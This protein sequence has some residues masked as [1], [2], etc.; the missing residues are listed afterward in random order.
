MS[1]LRYA[2][3]DPTGNITVL[4]T[5]PVPREKQ[6]AL[7]RAL[8]AEPKVGGEQ[9][10]F[11][12]KPENPACRCR[13]QMMGGEFC[14][15]ATMS[16]AAYLVRNE[17]ADG[18]ETTVPLEVSGAEGVLDCRIRRVDDTFEGT[19]RMPE[20][21]ACDQVELP[22][23]GRKVLLTSVRLDGITH[24]ILKEKIADD[25]EAE[26]MLRVWAAL[27][28]DEAV[29]LLQWNDAEGVMRPLVLVKP[30]GTAVWETGCGSG[31]AAVGVMKALESKAPVA[32]TDVRQS[33]GTIRVTVNQNEIGPL[34][35]TITGQVRLVRVGAIDLD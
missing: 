9:V 5:D 28:K 27:C 34:T 30:T 35:L 29:G 10:G 21:K 8:M 32:V 3:M 1:T 33:G 25:A 12:E 2:I 14:G 11:L 26:Q 22:W 23:N 19:V 13:L 15:N 17:L 24:L 16:L 7:A 31:S 20:A 18:Q 4:V 6:A